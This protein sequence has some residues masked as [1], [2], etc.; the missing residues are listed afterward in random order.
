MIIIDKLPAN[1]NINTIIFDIDSTITQWKNV[2]LFLEE[3]LKS[4]KVPYID[5]AL[6]GLFNAMKYRE[7][8][9]VIT[10]E[11]DEKIYSILLEQYIDILHKYNI[12]GEQLKDTMFK[13]EAEQTFISDEVPKEIEMLSKN[14]KLYC[15]TNWFKEQAISKL[16]K[17]GLTKYFEMIYSSED[18]YLKFSKVGFDWLI[19]KHNLDANK[20]IAIGD[21]KTDIIP[22]VNAGMHAIYLNYN[23]GNVITE[24]KFRLF[25]TADASITEFK[26]IRTVLTKKL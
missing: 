2:K 21:S 19:K 26:D 22:S 18:I 10:G 7:H 4:L 23:L 25:E 16:D 1:N 12:S 11:A 5:E 6:V 8:H 13:L 3:A 20:T 9:A 24:E 15:Y 17:Y 14:Y